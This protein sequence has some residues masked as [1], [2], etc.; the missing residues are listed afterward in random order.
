[1]V[2]VELVIAEATSRVPLSTASPIGSP[3]LQRFTNSVEPRQQFLKLAAIQSNFVATAASIPAFATPFAH[4]NSPVGPCVRGD[5]DWSYGLNNGIGPYNWFCGSGITAKMNAQ[6]DD[7]LGL[8]IVGTLLAGIAWILMTMVMQGST[9]LVGRAYAYEAVCGTMVASGF[10]TL[11]SVGVFDNSGIKKAFCNVF[12][13]NGTTYCGYYTGFDAVR[14][15]EQRAACWSPFSQSQLCFVAPPLS[16]HPHSLP[17]PPPPP[18]HP[19]SAGHRRHGLQLCKRGAV[20]AVD[21][22]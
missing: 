13:P 1:M 17:T 18:P 9:A 16:R 20:L 3:W 6:V 5:P 10:F 14:G 8:M 7:S 15:T 12:E 22:P 11:C 21:A 2:M 4:L 19:L